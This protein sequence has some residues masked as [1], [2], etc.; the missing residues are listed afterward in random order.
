MVRFIY[1][2]FSI[3]LI[4]VLY[5]VSN[6]VINFG[7]EYRKIRKILEMKLHKKKSKNKKKINITFLLVI[8]IVVIL[9]EAVEEEE[10][11]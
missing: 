3:S 8:I 4:F 7:S 5:S 1:S 9:I 10:K 11:I 2:L 6:N